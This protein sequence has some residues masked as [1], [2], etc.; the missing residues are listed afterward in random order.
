MKSVEITETENIFQ[1]SNQ[2]S[3]IQFYEDPYR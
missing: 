1:N 2:N 3:N